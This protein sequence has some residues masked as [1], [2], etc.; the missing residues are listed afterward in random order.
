VR[1]LVQGFADCLVDNFL[2]I[3]FGD[4]IAFGSNGFGIVYNVDIIND[5]RLI[6]DWV[7]LSQTDT[8]GTVR[9]FRRNHV[10]NVL[11][12]S[13]VVAKADIVIKVS[14]VVVVNVIVSLELLLWRYLII[15]I[16]MRVHLVAHLSIYRLVIIDKLL[17][18]VKSAHCL[19]NFFVFI[20][21]VLVIYIIDTTYTFTIYNV[22]IQRI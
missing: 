3:I 7:N 1:K 20:P 8:A 15:V 19:R 16:R 6:N 21:Q 11:L 12:T 9:R 22:R 17:L 5:L 2:Y 4:H 18:R 14:V 13:I 10:W